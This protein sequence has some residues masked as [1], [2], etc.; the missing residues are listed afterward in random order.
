MAALDEQDRE[1]QQELLRDAQELNRCLNSGMGLLTL[2]HVRQIACTVTGTNK[3]PMEVLRGLNERLVILGEENP[4]VSSAKLEQA[5][6]SALQ[7][8]IDGAKNAKE[9]Q[10]K[11][12]PWQTLAA[13]EVPR[14]ALRLPE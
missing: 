8:L 14:E 9:R 7:A 5:A 13:F 6:E 11:L 12:G 3:E 1:R 10:W 4:Q 2:M